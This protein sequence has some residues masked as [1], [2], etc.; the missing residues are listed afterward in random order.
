MID[1]MLDDTGMKTLGHA[2][3]LVSVEMQAAIADMGGTF[4][5]TAQTRNRETAF[6][7]AFGGTIEHFD[8]GI[9]EHSERRGVV[10]ALFFRK[11]LLGAAFGRLEDDEAQG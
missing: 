5:E 3:D 2:F 8:F 11:F 9:D 10:V 4:D 7:T 1:F 6:P